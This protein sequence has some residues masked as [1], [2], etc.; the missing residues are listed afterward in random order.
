MKPAVVEITARIRERSA[1]TRGEYLRDIDATVARPRGSER[2]GCA[3][4]AHAFAAL[5]RNDKL[6]VVA[7]RAPHIAIVT[8]YNDVLS[9]HQPYQAYPEIIRDEARRG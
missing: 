5:P 3:N 9:A 2:M 8:A 6:R 7:Q 4:I 1:A